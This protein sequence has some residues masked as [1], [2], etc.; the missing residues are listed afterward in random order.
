MYDAIVV[1]SGPNGLCAAITLQQQG[2]SVLLIEGRDTVGGGLRS[3]A[4]TLPGLVHD[5]CSA[6]HPMAVAS[7]L[8]SSLPLQKHGL[9]FVF[10]EICAAHPLDNGE[11]AVLHCSLSD[12]AQSLG[13]DGAAYR[14]LIE[15]IIESWPLIVNNLLGPLRFPSHPLPYTQFGLQAIRSADAVVKR[16]K[17]R[18][19]RALWAGMSAHSMLPLSYASSAAIGLVLSAVG[20]VHGWPIARGGSQRIADALASLFV[21]LGGTIETAHFVKSLSELPPAKAVLL[22]VSAQQLL[23]IAGHKLSSVYR[24]QLKRYR[25][26]MGAFKVDFAL[27]GPIP[28]ANE[29]CRQAATVHIGNTYEDIARSEL[30]TWKNSPDD[31]PFVLVAQQSVHDTSRADGRHHTVWAYC[32]VPNGSDKDM[33]RVI[34]QQ[35]ERYAPGFRDRIVAKHVMSP[36]ALEDYNPNYVGGDI[37]GGAID[38]CQLFSRPALRWSPYRTSAKGIY[39]CSASSPPGGGVH[40]MCGYHAARRALK[41]VFKIKLASAPKRVP[42]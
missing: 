14:D 20:H 36:A 5:V 27:D 13:N 22:D 28:F 10:P 32:H 23:Q 29:A 16:F 9:E 42:Q 2:L 33:T 34:E 30:A 21:S 6:I 19:A 39:I 31:K 35:I 1:G 26:G 25:S 40:G 3:R 8:L 17:T 24:W 7:P 41:D 11:A 4:L 15:P 18:R 37:N 38:V 12:T